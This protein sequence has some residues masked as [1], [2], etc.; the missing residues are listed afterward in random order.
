M[1]AIP[2][3][4]LFAGPGGLSHGF[5]VS[6]SLGVR[7]PI[8][9]SVEKDPIAHRTLHLRAFLRQFEAPPKEYY[10]YIKS[11]SE[12]GRQKLKEMYA[13]EWL[14]ADRE[15]RNW[16]LGKVPFKQISQAIKDALGNY[17]KRWLLL[18]GPPC[19]AY[20]LAGR[21]RM[22]HLRG[23]AADHRHTL[24][25]EYLKIVAVH[26]P[27]VF[28]ME[29]VKGIL[30]SK[31][32]TTQK[33]TSI[34][35]QILNDLRQ[36]GIAVSSMPGMARLLSLKRSQHEYKIYSF[37]VSRTRA[38][39]LRP[40]EFVIRSEDWGVPQTRH[41]VILL[42]V[43][44]DIRGLPRTLGELFPRTTTS[45]GSVISTMPKLRSQL[46]RGR[47][48]DRNWLEAV[49]SVSSPDVIGEIEDKNVRRQVILAAKSMKVPKHTGAHFI[50]SRKGPH[51]AQLTGWLL[52]HR[53]RGVIQHEA[54]SHMP[55]DLARYFFAAIYATVTG[56]SPTLKCFPRSL[57]PCHRNVHRSV[58]SGS[59]DFGDR[60]RVQIRAKP[61]T[62]ITSHISKDGHYYIHFDFQQCR[63]LT[64][65]EAARVQTFPDS[66][67][68][69]GNRTQQYQQVGNAVPPLLAYKLAKVVADLLKRDNAK[70]APYTQTHDLA[71]VL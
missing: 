21:S 65:R 70:H 22:K 32:G 3:I 64:V 18:G 13:A 54:R 53:L 28:L 52:D 20:S 38:E 71:E 57:L 69:E 58:R 48:S 62:T 68:F 10:E 41:R 66:Y 59:E 49:R 19:Q 37:V 29:N 50:P 6:S 43:R 15:A 33:S 39:D 31:Y 46:S 63:S 42:G 7:F 17:Q 45:V 16:E 40:E 4:D 9:L 27:A 34:F 8:V 51:T 44:D 5:S 30:S 11:P 61:A 56:R 25:K 35:Q 24:Y 2:V 55:T 26:E 12:A 36:P 60:F 47:D 23:F 1:T 67:L 14:A